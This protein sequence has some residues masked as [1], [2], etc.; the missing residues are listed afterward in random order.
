VVHLQNIDALTF[1]I[2]FNT[3]KYFAIFFFNQLMAF[4]DIKSK[5]EKENK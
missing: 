3:T 4:W 2:Q 5:T 1:I